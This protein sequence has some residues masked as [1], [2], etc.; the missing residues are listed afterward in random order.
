MPHV[1]FLVI[2]LICVPFKHAMSLEGA[3]E[4]NQAC[5]ETGCFPGDDPGFPV[6]LTTPGNYV[7]TSNLTVTE[8]GTGGIAIPS[9]YVNLDLRGFAVSGPVRCSGEPVSCNI[10]DFGGIGINGSGITFGNT[11]RN[12]TVRGFGWG[13][14]TDLSW[15]VTGIVS[16]QNTNRGFFIRQGSIVEDS[17]ARFNAGSGFMVGRL[18]KVI[19]STVFRNNTGI[20][21]FDTDPGNGG[22]GGATLT[23]NTIMQNQIGI[24]EHGRALVL[25]NSIFRNIDQGILSVNGG[26]H[27]IDNRIMDNGGLGLELSGG[28][29]FA[30]GGLLSL[31]RGNQ[32]S[33]NAGSLDGAQIGGAGSF[34]ESGINFCGVDMNCP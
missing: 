17:A 28:S 31:L 30:P 13:V 11:V 19:D 22:F 9:D 1:W 23:G 27:L 7:L 12:G 34:S 14:A 21:T 29:F 3:F 16:E 15:R 24:R 18:G 32:L 25:R 4:I 8:P 33:N 20:T 26:T 2:L 6:A 5:V 10:T